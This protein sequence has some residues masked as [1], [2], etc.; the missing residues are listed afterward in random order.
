MNTYSLSEK[1]KAFFSLIRWKNLLIIA[2]TLSAL[3]L[4]G[5]EKSSNDTLF[6]FLI[7]L[8]AVIA[9]MAAGNVINDIYDYK[10]D[11]LNKPTRVIVD[12]LIGKKSAFIIY[13]IL[14]HYRYLLSPTV[15]I[16]RILFNSYFCLVALFIQT[17]ES[18]NYR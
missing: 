13:L 6:V 1:L 4:K 9:V 18:T 17:K 2:A 10:I 5:T 14:K 8:G 11:Q 16:L 3:Y 7:Y 15:A 12:R